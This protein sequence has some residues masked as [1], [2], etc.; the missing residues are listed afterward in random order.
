MSKSRNRVTP[1]LVFILIVLIWILVALIIYKAMSNGVFEK[2]L[3]LNDDLVQELYSYVTDEDI[4]LY[5]SNK[6]DINSLPSE[7]IFSKATKVMTLEDIE[8]SNNQFTIDYDSLDGAIKTTFGPDIK[9]DLSNINGEVQTYLETE[10]EYKIILN[11]KYDSKNKKYY[12][13]YSTTGKENEVK[14]KKSLV[15]ATKGEYVNLKVG[16]VFYKFDND[17]Y[18]I[19]SNEK[20]ERVVKEVE[21]I[22]DYKF[23]SFVNISLKKASDEVYYYYKNS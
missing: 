5:S 22:D 8:L 16:Y 1:I 17:K 20:C 19:C 11:V 10:E 7:Y 12:G 6:Y 23:D 13:T 21:N 3:K 14:I 9:Y 18:K 2:K 4:I 15:S